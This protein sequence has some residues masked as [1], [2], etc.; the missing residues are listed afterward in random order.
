[1]K[2]L[3]SIGGKLAHA[4]LAVALLLGLS[5]TAS[6][7]LILQISD[8]ITTQ[9]I[10][11]GGAGDLSGGV[12]DVILFN[13]SIGV[14]T[15]NV[16]TGIGSGVLGSP[17]YPQIDLNSVNVSTA[18]GTL[19][20]YLVDTDLTTNVDPFGVVFGIGG[21]TQGTVFT[22][23]CV[24]NSNTL[25]P[26]DVCNPLQVANLGP[27]SGGAFSGQTSFSPVGTNNGPFALKLAVLITHEGAGV[28]SF[29]ANLNSVPEP[30]TMLLSGIA[31]LGLG[32]LGRRVKKV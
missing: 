22:S 19:L 9:L 20:M 11:D 7:A 2:L 29:D 6:A 32:L 24:D 12:D 3:N 14:W 28:T 17:N 10:S 27:F 1:M 18:A 15:V 13:G 8:G 4:S 25:T 16:T 23:A 31:L 21:T 30:S 26:V 5:T